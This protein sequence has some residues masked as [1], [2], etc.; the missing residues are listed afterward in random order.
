MSC[1]GHDTLR[2]LT[3]AFGS[4]VRSLRH[5]RGFTVEALARRAGLHPATVGRIERG[6][7]PTLPAINA[8][9]QALDVPSVELANEA[10][11]DV[12]RSAEPI[13]AAG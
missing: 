3:V 2:G 11:R 5:L 8:L 7:A 12:A 9:A 4:R 1:L 6:L 10:L 13:E